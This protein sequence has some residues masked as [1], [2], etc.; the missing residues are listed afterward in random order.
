MENLKVKSSV[1]QDEQFKVWKKKWNDRSQLNNNTSKNKLNLMKKANPHIIPRNYHVEEALKNAI[2][3]NDITKFSKLMNTI[4]DNNC[5][6]TTL[7][8]SI[9]RS[10]K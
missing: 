1:F 10:K 6:K 7:F 9:S 4:K 2:E 5:D 8:L 3:N